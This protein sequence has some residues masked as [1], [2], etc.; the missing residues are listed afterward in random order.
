MDSKNVKRPYTLLLLSFFLLAYILPLGSRHLIIPDET[1][2]AEI[3]REMISSGDWVVPHINGARY[4]EKPVMGY[5]IH[6][7]SFL[8]FG[9]NNFAVRFPS[10]LAV[11]LTALLIYILV[12]HI[13]CRAGEEEEPAAA[14]AAL[15]YLSCFEVF[16]VGNTAV[17]DSLF[18]FMVTATIAAFYF[19]TEAPR[20]S[21]KEKF[22]LLLA[23]IVCGM[24]FLTKG[25]LAFAIPV[26]S[27]APYLVWQRRYL[28]LF[29]MAWLPILTAIVV[30]LPWGIS[31]HLREPDFWHFF[32]FN[33][34]L[35]RFLSDTA[36]HRQPFWSFFLSSLPMFLPWLLLVP[37][38][39]PGIWKFYRDPGTKGRLFRLS[40]CWF[41]LPFLFFSASEGKLLTYILPCFPPFAMVLSLSF[42]H[43]LKKEV[44]NPL[45]QWGILGNGIL[46]AIIVLA[47]LYLLVF[48]YRG[49][50]PYSQLWVSVLAMGGLT[51]LL[52]FHVFAFKYLKGPGKVL[53]LGFAP[54]VLFVA[55]PFIIPD[56]TTEA[57]SPG[58][59]LERNKHA[60]GANDIIITS[61]KTVKAACWY[62][63]R[64][65]IHVLGNA[66]ELQYGMEYKD[67]GARVID[68]TAAKE[69]ILTNPGKAVVI[70]STKELKQWP[71]GFPEPVF[72]DDSGPRGYTLWRY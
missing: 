34:H 18:T 11:G 28:D 9:E 61:R 36:D 57:K 72:K 6:A 17:L 39:F 16:G 25:F 50:K 32:I 12:C 8:L 15:I 71:V 42:L 55:S 10:A 13:N 58:P 68:L 14:L 52:F 3:P 40:I 62:L 51:S 53:L 23:G 49:F 26:L 45:F 37:A 69:L 5:W 46:L 1:R 38:A 54:L 43:I 33:E 63:K 56:L 22:L 35:R 44:K 24:A 20:G 41:V 27:L 59:L 70:V 21:G 31:I 66:G 30:I 67:A 7:A 65:N 29:R 48:G 2:Y 60:I 4:F 64:D 47:A 19:A